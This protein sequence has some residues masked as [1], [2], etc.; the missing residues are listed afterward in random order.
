MFHRS[1]GAHIVHIP[2]PLMA[3]VVA[4]A[5][6]LSTTASAHLDV[7]FLLDTTGSMGGELSEAKTRVKEISAALSAARPQERIRTGVVAYRDQGDAYVTQAS[8]LTDDIDVTHAFLNTLRAG[9]G[10]DGPE[11]VLSGL[12]VALDFAWDQGAKTE[13]QIFLIADAPAHEDYENHPTMDALVDEA[14]RKKVVV[15]A[16]G[17]R[18]LS[19]A[20]RAQFRALSRRTEG[21]FQHIGRVAVAQDVSLVDAILTAAAPTVERVYREATVKTVTPHTNPRKA[22]SSAPPTIEVRLLP[23]KASDDGS[24]AKVCHAKA[25]VP[26]GLSLVAA[27]EVASG[28][29]ARVDVRLHVKAGRGQNAVAAM[30]FAL[31]ECVLPSAAVHVEVGG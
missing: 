19:N 9:G 8:A 29:E 21:R 26:L 4:V 17:C 24:V 10:G 23:S 6:L 1:L 3:A 15:H 22:R 27:P 16:I 12:Q 18:S 7:V 13:R 5:C 14:L 11:D 20:G 2:F 30:R 31:P 25:T 28:T